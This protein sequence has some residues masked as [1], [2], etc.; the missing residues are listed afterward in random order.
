MLQGDIGLGRPI[1]LPIMGEG[2]VRLASLVL[3]LA[4]ASNGV[5]LIDEIENGLHH[6][7]MPKLWSA[8]GDV[9]REFN[10]QLFAST[11]SLEC[12]KA[13]HRAFTE[14]GKYDLRVHRLERTKKGIK[15]VTYD[16]EDLS[17]AFETSME[18]R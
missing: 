4:I 10:T 6:S 5:V 12:I 18:I 16:Q 8:I 13:A 15:A 11:H 2:M 1:P 3:R 14:G 17:V 7:I 9:A